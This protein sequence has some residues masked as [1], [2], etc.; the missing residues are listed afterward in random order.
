MEFLTLEVSKELDRIRAS[1]IADSD[2]HLQTIGK[3]ATD[4]QLY[5]LSQTT[6]LGTAQNE[7]ERIFT[8]LLKE[9]SKLSEDIEVALDIGLI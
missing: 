2:F 1:L 3:T 5:L 4:L 8:N 9:H 6:L 7:R